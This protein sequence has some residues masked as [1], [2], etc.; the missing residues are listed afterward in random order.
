MSVGCAGESAA[1]W[2][3]CSCC[4][5][6]F[7]PDRLV[8]FQRNPEDGVCIQCAAW[9]NDRSRIIARRIYAPIRWRRRKPRGQAS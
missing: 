9:L 1:D 8:R 2:L 4:G 7:P 5:L 6:A 3:A